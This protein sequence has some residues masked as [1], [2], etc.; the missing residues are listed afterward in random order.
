MRVSVLQDQLQRAITTVI[1]AVLNRPTLP[2]LANI[3]IQTEDARLKIA[4]TTIEMSITTYIGA[5]VDRPGAITLPA[6]TLQELI[7]NFPPDRID[8]T[9]D[10]PT[11]TVNLRCGASTSNLKG[12]AASE[13]PPLLDAT[14]EWSLKMSGKD[15]KQA[16]D[17]VMYSVSREESRP[18]L[19]GLC[20]QMKNGQLRWL[21]ADGYRAAIRVFGAGTEHVLKDGDNFIIPGPALAQTARLC[22]DAEVTIHLTRDYASFSFGSTLIRSQLLS[23]KF[24]DL[25]AIFPTSWSTRA[26][27]Y[28]A[29]L[30]AVTKRAAIFGRDSNGAVL[31]TVSP[32]ANPTHPGDILVR[33]VSAERGDCESTMDAAVEG[34]ELYAKYGS[35]YLMDAIE[36][37]GTELVI[38]ETNGAAHPLVVRQEGQNDYTAVIMPMS[39]NR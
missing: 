32:P 12:I 22:F 20:I 13:F 31:I 34:E 11:Q 17:Q 2:I 33:G 30:L 16:V 15:F 26:T 1:K 19:T 14:D 36:V 7:N 9:L 21:S 4:A 39:V 5:K 18:I 29:D 3:L 23:G 8:L 24:P 37:L 27:V 25:D 6:K 38:L 10:A 35:A 28:V